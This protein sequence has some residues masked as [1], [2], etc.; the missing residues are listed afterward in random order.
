MN[1]EEKILYFMTA[2][3]DV[4]KDDDNKESWN[5]PKFELSDDTLTEDFTAMLYALKVFYSNITGDDG[6]IFDFIG[7]L[8]RLAIQHSFNDN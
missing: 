2:L 3:Q 7:I 6:D 4:Y 8:N 5:I 1:F